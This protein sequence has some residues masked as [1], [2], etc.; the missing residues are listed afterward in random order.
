MLRITILKE[1]N[2]HEKGRERG[3]EETATAAVVLA[4]TVPLLA[5][6]VDL[7]L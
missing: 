2:S 5:A 7:L 1:S 3:E 4:V 6:T